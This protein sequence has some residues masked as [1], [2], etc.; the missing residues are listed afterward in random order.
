MVIGYIIRFRMVNERK[1]FVKKKIFVFQLLLHVLFSAALSQQISFCK[2]ETRPPSKATTTQKK[3]INLFSYRSP[4][5]SVGEIWPRHS[6]VHVDYKY[7]QT[8]DENEYRCV[9]SF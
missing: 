5:H 1:S 3:L 4:G 9:P 7:I 6:Q 2:I 8:N